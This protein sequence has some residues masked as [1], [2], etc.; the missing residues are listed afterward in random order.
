MKIQPL[1]F[2]SMGVRSMATCI[3][4]DQ[5]IM[6]DPGAALGPM[7]YSLPPHP[8]ELSKLNELSELVEGCTKISGILIISHYHYDHYFPC[9]TDIYKNKILL[10]KDPKHSINYSQKD[11][12]KNFLEE[13]KNLPH[14]IEFADSREF[15]FNET[16][17]KFSPAVRHGAVNSKLGF[18][19]MTSISYKNERLI[20]AS[21]IQGPETDETTGWIINENPDVLIL[22]GYPTLFIGWRLS[23]Q[24]LEK[25]NENL[26]KILEETKVKTV[27]LDHHL[28]RDLYYKTKIL[29]VLETAKKQGKNVV[30]AAEFLGRENEFLEARRKELYKQ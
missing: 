16:E 30:T 6:I 20:H 10:I 17:I 18:V 11:R 12:A 2:D 9:G 22:S 28:V 25:S 3:E 15:K 24:G 26:I 1:A 21:D 29:G 14:R 27:V 8:V 13:I 19:I 4:T 7:R 23:Q 5:K